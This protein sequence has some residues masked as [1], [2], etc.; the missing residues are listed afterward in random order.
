MPPWILYGILHSIILKELWVVTTACLWAWFYR[1]LHE[2]PFLSCQQFIMRV[3]IKEGMCRHLKVAMKFS[4]FYI[5]VLMYVMCV[6]YVYYIYKYNMFAIIWILDCWLPD[7]CFLE[8]NTVSWPGKL[9]SVNALEKPY[10][11]VTIRALTAVCIS[12]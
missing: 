7:T 5:C 11:Y 9:L 1:V 3:D 8:T 12:S 2:F 6:I 4:H 10:P